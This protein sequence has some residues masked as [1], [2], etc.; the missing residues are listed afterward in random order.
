MTSRVNRTLALLPGAF[1]V[2]QD[3]ESIVS[4]PK[5]SGVSLLRYS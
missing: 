2:I 3:W 5:P 4:G 1:D